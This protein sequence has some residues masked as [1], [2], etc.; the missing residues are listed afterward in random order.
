MKLYGVGVGPGDPDWLTMK[1][2]HVIQEADIIMTPI[3]NQDKQSIAL[4]IVEKYI[5]NQKIHRV[6]FPMTSD[7]IRL[8]V[9][10]EEARNDL[11]QFLMEGKTVAFIT[12]GDPLLYST[13]IYLKHSI[14]EQLSNLSIEVVPGIPSFVALS[15][16][17]QIPIAERD[18]NLVVI[19]VI[20][21]LDEVKKAIELHDNIILMKI[22]KDYPAI[23]ELLDE[24]Q[25]LDCC[26]VGQRIGMEDSIITNQP[27]E[28]LN[29][30]L[31][32]LTTM[33]IKKKR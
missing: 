31:D 8:Q 22:N 13:F 7:P 27:K 12:L 5:T 16:M 32:Y 17:A 4:S 10:W 19:P 24:M 3:S 9:A 26:W 15:A 2:V 30:K 6:I 29:G 33:M 21:S 1:A 11:A 20:R 28:L 18:E 14:Q 25:L 23:V